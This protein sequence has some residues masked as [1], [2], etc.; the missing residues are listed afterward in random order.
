MKYAPRPCDGDDVCECG[1][2]RSRHWY[3][4]FFHWLFTTK[5]TGNCFACMCSKFTDSNIGKGVKK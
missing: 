3:R 4:S 2:E 1:H 5:L